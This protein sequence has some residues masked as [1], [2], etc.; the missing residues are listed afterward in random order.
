MRE[1]YITMSTKEV[2]RLEVIQKVVD[3]RLKQKHAAN[4]LG[5]STR[6]IIRLVKA[7]KRAGHVSL[8]SKK[9]GKQ[10]NHCYTQEFKNKV[11]GII[12]EQYYD[13][14]PTLAS[15]QLGLRNDIKI[16][17]ETTRQLMIQEG[18]WKPKI[19]KKKVVHPPRSRRP[20]YGELIQI[21]GSEHDWFEGRAPRCTLLVF[22]DDATSRIQLIRFFNSETTFAYFQMMRLYLERYGKPVALYS[23]KFGVFR[24]NHP[25]PVSGTGL[26]QF[27]R[28]MK[29]LDIEL[30]FAHSPQAKGRVERAN[31]TLQDRL[32]KELRLKGISDME[33]ANQ[34]LDEYTEYHNSK[35]AVLPRD[36]ID[37]HR[38][39]KNL[40][41]LDLDFTHQEMRKVNKNLSVQYL[42]KIYVINVP[43]KGY[44]LRQAEVTVCEAESGEITLLHKGQSLS[45]KVYDKKQHYSKT[46]SGKDLGS[47][48]EVVKHQ[49]AKPFFHHKPAANH[50]WRKYQKEKYVKKPNKKTDYKHLNLVSNLE[51]SH[52]TTGNK[53]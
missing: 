51:S 45:Y 49:I 43:G 37:V 34:F 44:R 52:P 35:F 11:I 23:D 4:I 25:E 50:P 40:T 12:K 26:T 29:S 36:P 47:H 22:I 48:L 41:S 5:L 46:I 21:D 3:K 9:R 38:A 15:E 10:S 24:V 27:G 17:V 13:F 16:S 8:V 14:G 39:F 2:G 31:G 53:G 18:L 42:N 33:K 30:I 6:Q 20:C 32:I 19:A 7:F 1:E 28:A